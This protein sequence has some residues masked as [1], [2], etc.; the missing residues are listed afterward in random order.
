MDTMKKAEEM[1]RWQWEKMYDGQH[2]EAHRLHSLYIMLSIFADTHAYTLYRYGS[3]FG[4]VS[5][6]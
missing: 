1:G 4:D 3:I 5:N 6:T 2:V